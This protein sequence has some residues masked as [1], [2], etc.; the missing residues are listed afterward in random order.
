MGLLLLL[1]L[2]FFIFSLF[3]VLSLKISGS[4]PRWLWERLGDSGEG[5]RIMASYM[6]G[7]GSTT[8]WHLA[9]IFFDELRLA[10]MVPWLELCKRSILYE[11]GLALLLPP[12]TSLMSRA[13]GAARLHPPF[14][15]LELGSRHN[16]NLCWLLQCAWS[17]ARSFSVVAAAVF[18]YAFWWPNSQ[19]PRSLIHEPRKDINSTLR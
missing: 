6:L 13:C 3:F 5:V 10:Y 18:E 9:R 19:P 12:P 4:D 2:L 11:T 8:E 14:L 16:I 7:K 15:A 1:L 17:T